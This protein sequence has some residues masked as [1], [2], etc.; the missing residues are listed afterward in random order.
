MSTKH[1]FDTLNPR[2]TR[3]IFIS[4][5]WLPRW[6]EYGLTVGFFFGL[7]ALVLSYFDVLFY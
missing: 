2:L 3:E 1:Q 5:P 6:V 7:L 4:R